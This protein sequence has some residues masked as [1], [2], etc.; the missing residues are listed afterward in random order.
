MPPAPRLDLSTVTELGL[1]SACTR[2]SSGASRPSACCPVP[3]PPPCCSGR[4]SPPVRS[5]CAGSMA[6]RPCS[7]HPPT[8]TSPPD[9]PHHVSSVPAPPNFHQLRDTT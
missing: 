9:P 6:G 2:S 1:S 4:S 7:A 3:R 8:L 5:P